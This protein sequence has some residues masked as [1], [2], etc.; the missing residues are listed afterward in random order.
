ML[1]GL[2]GAETSEGLS[3]VEGRFSGPFASAVECIREGVGRQEDYERHATPAFEILFDAIEHRL[4]DVQEVV[5]ALGQAV[6]ALEPVLGEVAGKL[7]E[8]CDVA[9]AA[10]ERGGAWLAEHRDVLEAAAKLIVLVALAVEAPELAMALV[11]KD[12]SI[13]NG[14]LRTVAEAV[15]DA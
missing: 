4:E 2:E 8:G 3:Q 5:H 10:L 11:S 13:L 15:R 14:P 1:K 12:P 6:R 9:E 7:G